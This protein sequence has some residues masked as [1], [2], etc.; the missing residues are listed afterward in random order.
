MRLY[1]FIFFIHLANPV[2][3]QS[4]DMTAFFIQIYP[5]RISIKSPKTLEK[6]LNITVENKTLFNVTAKISNASK[7]LSFLT[8]FSQSKKTVSIKLET[9]E[10]LKFVPISPSLHEVELLAGRELYEIP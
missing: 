6:I 5:D 10:N 7:D 1:F 3:A 8:I 2:Y 4:E 9:L